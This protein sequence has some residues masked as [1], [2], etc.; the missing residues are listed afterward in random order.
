VT[1]VAR[2]NVNEMTRQ[3]LNR[4][5]DMSLDLRPPML[6]D[7]GL[8]PTL[9]WHFERYR[10][11]TGIQVSFHHEGVTERLGV[12]EITAFRIIQEALTNVARHAG[13]VEARVDL[14][15]ADGRIGIRVADQGRGFD[16]AKLRRASSGLAGM[17][18]RALLLGGTLAV[19]SAPGGGTRVVAHLPLQG[20]A[21]A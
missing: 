5:R 18:E 2:E 15:A 17:R 8:V 12:G 19:E 13:V 9:L 4:L 14:W 3:L 20:G 21:V 11:Q 16:Q 6:D 10:A 7:L 1:A